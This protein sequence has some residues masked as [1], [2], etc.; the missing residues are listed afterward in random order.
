MEEKGGP[1]NN[2]GLLHEE[3]GT[4]I[5]PRP[6]LGT[7]RN[8]VTMTIVHTLTTPLPRGPGKASRYLA[9]GKTGVLKRQ[10]GLESSRQSSG[11]MHVVWA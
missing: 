2:Q 1:P 3:A 8:L 11:A 6:R 5:K 7:S 9:E 10:P 4:K